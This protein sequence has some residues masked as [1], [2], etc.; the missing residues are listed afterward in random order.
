MKQNI[1]ILLLCLFFTISLSAQNFTVKDYQVNINLLQDGSF[2]V[3]ENIQLQF[4]K[5]QRGIIREIEKEGSFQNHVQAIQISDVTVKDWKYD[6]SNKRKKLTVK[7]GDKDIY[8]EGNQAYKISYHV[9]NG[10]IPFE[11]HDEFYWQLTG[12]EWTSEIRNVNFTINL[13]ERL[14]LNDRDI[15]VFTGE[16]ISNREYASVGINENIISGQS[17]TSL[18]KGKGITVALTIPK[19][20]FPI[21]SYSSQEKAQAS[22]SKPIKNYPKDFSFPLPILLS[23]FLIYLFRKWG[24][25]PKQRIDEEVYYPPSSLTPS[26]VGT[27]HDYTVNHRDVIAL[28][29]YWGEKGFLKV[30]ALKGEEDKAELYLEKISELPDESPEYEKLLFTKIFDFGNLVF[31]DEMKNEMYT[32]FGKVGTMLKKDVLE[33]ELYDEDAKQKF[34]SGR[35]IILSVVAVALAIFLMIMYHAFFTGIGLIIFGIIA[36][37]IHF[38]QPRKSQKGIDLHNQLESFK[39]T[40]TKPNQKELEKILKNDPMYFEKVFPYVVAFGI[41]KDWIKQFE[42]IFNEAPSWYYHDQSMMYPAGFPTFS[43][44]FRV[45]DIKN[46]MTSSPHVANSSNS[47]F[48]GGGSVGGGFGGGGGSSW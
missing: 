13:P 45:N 19:G 32:T 37:V 39:K 10:I 41:D 14:Q 40:L 27:F 42:G 47:A 48:G 34:H 33:K 24:R 21:Q 35:L 1:S 43:E 15:I 5:K 28:I 30:K 38:L 2:D 22:S 3:S 4:H 20:F 18:G 12:T 7:I 26:E 29:P 9:E 6:V 16:S 46:V 8:L 11:D 23:G 17:L 25:H 44:N 31:L 36:F